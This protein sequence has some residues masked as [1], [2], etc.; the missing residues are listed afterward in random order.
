MSLSREYYIRRAMQERVLSRMAE[1]ADIAEIH[2]EIALWFQGKADAS[3][4]RPTSRGPF[5]I[6]IVA[7]LSKVD[8]P[9]GLGL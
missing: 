8:R 9:C 3:E 6:S 7:S 1:N 2:L 4:D 5:P